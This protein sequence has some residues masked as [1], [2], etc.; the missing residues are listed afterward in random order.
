MDK[1]GADLMLLSRPGSYV[2]QKTPEIAISYGGGGA[3]ELGAP[4]GEPDSMSWAIL[5]PRADGQ[6]P[7][8]LPQM[9]LTLNC[10]SR[11]WRGACSAVAGAGLPGA[12][13]G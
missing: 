13:P 3:G 11:N 8:D 10:T 5:N 4:Q 1:A 7:Q 6:A 9:T 2:A 12:G